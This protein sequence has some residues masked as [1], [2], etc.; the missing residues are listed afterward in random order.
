MG[1]RAGAAAGEP[2]VIAWVLA[3]G[4]SLPIDTA[5][6]ST[7]THPSSTSSSSA[8]T[9]E[10][11][12]SGASTSG[13]SGSGASSTVKSTDHCDDPDH[14]VY[15]SGT[16][17][18]FITIQDGI[19]G[20][21]TGDAVVVCPGTYH[22][23]IDFKG[24]AITVRSHAGAA[25]TTI[26]GR[27]IDSVVVMENWEPAES[28]LEGFTLTGGIA[29]PKRGHGGGI[30]VEW[31]SPTIRHNIIIGNAAMVAGGVYVRNGAATVHNNIIAWNSADEVSGGV[32][33]TA[34]AGAYR[35][36]TIYENNAPEGPVGEWFW[37]VADLVG[38]IMVSTTDAASPAIRVMETRG[39][40]FE[41]DYNLLWPQERMTT[42]G[43][44]WPEGRSLITSPPNFADVEG[45]DWRLAA[46]S[47]GEDQGPADELDADGSRADIGAFGGP[48]G[49]W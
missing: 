39:V 35:Y 32:S 7:T 9:S 5:D 12:S 47:P 2:P 46:G 16:Q 3:C 17:R 11:S 36:N 41:V 26:D 42:E 4:A 18:R 40:D 1:T 29:G 24:K 37:G 30:Y 6:R 28:V 20:A 21:E 48:S 45:G 31:G 38:N 34:C 23:N 8:G 15:I 19:W 25:Q 44:E 27:G 43:E 10:T 13:S 14:P 33:C 49:N 22:E